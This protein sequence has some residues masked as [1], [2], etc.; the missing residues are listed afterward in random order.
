MTISYEECRDLYRA[1]KAEERSSKDDR[2]AVRLAVATA[3]ATGVHTAVTS[4]T[5]ATATAAVAT[6]AV[7]GT[8]IGAGAGVVGGSAVG[9][10]G[11]IQLLVGGNFLTG[12]LVGAVVGTAVSATAF[13]AFPTREPRAN[14]AYSGKPT[15]LNHSPSNPS[16]LRA[17][18]AAAPVAETPSTNS[19]DQT[20]LKAPDKRSDR[21]G[22]STEQAAANPVFVQPIETPRPPVSAIASNPSQP[23]RQD[24]LLDE[25]QALARVQEALS[26]NNPSY[27]WSLLEKQ[28]RQFPA[29]QLGQER[30]AAKVLALCAAGR[31][32]EAE[33]ARNSFI[34]NYPGSPLASRVAKGC[35]H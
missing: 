5:A 14:V 18:P 12:L 34:A 32:K 27:A 16:S 8:G 13:V 17:R 35:T 10:K 30:A 20:G 31:E 25:A 24:R 29:G 2:R 6:S 26:H 15:N 9:A 7:V 33:Q 22:E 28:D 1:A 4:A 23:T 3:V 21:A 11:V 19:L